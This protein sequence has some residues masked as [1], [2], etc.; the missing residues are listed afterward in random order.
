MTV[1]KYKQLLKRTL[2]CQQKLTRQLGLL[3]KTFMK[4]TAGQL[5]FFPLKIT[6][7][8]GM[9]AMLFQY[10]QYKLFNYFMTLE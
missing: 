9:S 1:L 5:A 4:L 6:S 8:H 2:L 7:F 10:P 3:M